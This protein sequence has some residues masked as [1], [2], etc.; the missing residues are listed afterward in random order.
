MMQSSTL[1]KYA[2]F[3]GLMEEQIE[4]ILP[5]MVEEKFAPEEALIT[6]GNPNDKIFFIMEGQVAVIKKD[7]VLANFSDGDTFGE[8]EVLDVM[9]AAASIK[10]LTPVTAIT[11]SN[12]SL[13]EIYKKDITTY[14][15]IL[16]NLA[17]DLVRRLRKMDEKYAACEHIHYYQS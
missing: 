17:R 1:H 14:T 10:A 5:F 16:M 8:M 9:P 2:L 11:I 6:E 15:M 4:N 7:V 3:G 13:L 12:M